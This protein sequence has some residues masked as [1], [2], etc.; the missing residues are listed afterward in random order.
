MEANNYAGEE[1]SM[2]VDGPPRG[3]ARLKRMWMGAITIDLKNCNLSEDL[4]QD[5]PKSKN[6]IHMADPNVV[7]TRL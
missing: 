4:V 6:K 3:R 7:G 1:K 5:R 2:K